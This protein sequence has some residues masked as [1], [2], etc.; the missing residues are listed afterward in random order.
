M[1][2]TAKADPSTPSGEGT[3]P[4]MRAGTAYSF[5]D[6]RCELR[7]VPAIGE[8]EALVRV[9][10]SGICTG[11]VTP[12]YIN[13][14]VKKSGGSVVLGH[15][16]AGTIVELGPRAPGDFKVGDR[17]FVH[18]HAA[19]MRMD[20]PHCSRGEHVQCPTWK[21]TRIH[22]GGMAEF[23]RVEAQALATDTLV[24]PPNVSLSA[25]ALIEPLACSVK[26]V[27]R[28]GVRPGD[29]LAIIGVGIM[30]MLD[31]LVARAHGIDTIIVADFLDWRLDVAR[32]L[33]ASHT[34]NPKTQGNFADYV[35]Q[36]TGG[37]GARGV[38]VGPPAVPAIESGLASAAPG[39]T[40]TVF[41][42][43]PPEDRMTI[44]PHA[45][46]FPEITLNFSYSCGPTDTREA[47]RL[48]AV[49]QIP[50]RDL[51]TH[52]YA[53]DQIT[54]AFRFAATPGEHLK[55]MILFDDAPRS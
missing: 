4:N 28:V 16:P 31:L 9:G 25:G 38:I 50:E 51:I 35:K 13:N 32:K 5:E 46:Y 27:R 53:V 48:L 1:T 26:A 14:K 55:T 30:G 54:D 21:P 33:G 36:V 42:A 47:L 12:Y 40:V 2:A 20:C 18:H 10:A 17:V 45:L 39:G 8:D 3:A 49:G 41:M 29:S 43:T 37:I 44:S 15:E 11:D 24:L 23:M 34:F 52:T 22:P 6:V 7:V 19:C